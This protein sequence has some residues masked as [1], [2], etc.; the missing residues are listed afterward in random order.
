MGRTRWLVVG[1]LGVLLTA[2]SL[3][4]GAGAGQSSDTPTPPRLVTIAIPAQA[5]DIPS[6]WLGYSGPP[7]ANVLL[8]AGY[9]PHQRYPLLILLNGLESNYDWWATSGLAS[10]LNDLGAIVVMPEGASGWYT[11][12]WNGGERGSPS[13]ETY[14]LNDVIPAVMAL[15]PILPQRQYH[16]L[17]GVSM[18]GY[19]AVYLAGRLPGFFGSVATLSGFV[20]LDYFPGLVEPGMGLTALAPFKGD[21]NVDAV[22]GPPGGFYFQGHDPI[23]L[24]DNLEQTRVF[25]T[26]GTGMPSSAGLA[27]PGALPQVVEGSVLES[28]IIHPMNELYH[29]ALTAAGINVTYETHPGGHDIPDFANEVKAM[30]TWGLV[31]PVVSNPVSWVNRTV[32]TNGQLWDITYHF[33]GPPTQVVQF[34]QSGTALSISAAG[35]GVTVTTSGGCVTH[36]A[37]PAT[38]TLTLHTCH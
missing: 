23:S 31:K 32:A 30:L 1:V 5:G 33:D 15:Y 2:G 11:D 38:I 35:S 29:A 7:R 19:G 21:D 28:L 16:A 36:T 6:K 24:V 3:A 27:Q 10:A 20:D 34:Q 18:G 8:P 9:D 25:E 4:S 14:E 12:W 37:T 22:D 13:W 26:S 17:A